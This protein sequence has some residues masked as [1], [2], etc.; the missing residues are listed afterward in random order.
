[1]PSTNAIKEAAKPFV[2]R[3]ENLHADLESKRGAY[4]AECKVVREDIKLVYIEAKD[5]GLDPA[6]IKSY[7][8][9]CELERK[10]REIAAVLEP[11]TAATYEQ[12][13]DAFGPLGIA[14]ARS[15][16]FDVPEDERDLRP[17][18]LRRKT[19]RL[20]EQDEAARLASLQPH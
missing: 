14:A 3:I 9:S 11:D 5:V 19:E 1:M 15:A 7:V 4:M 8:K 18:Y 2:E 16:G 17:G 10:Q 13:I 12:L 20:D 6:A